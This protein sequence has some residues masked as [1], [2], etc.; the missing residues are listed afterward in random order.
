MAN[1]DKAWLG[2][3]ASKGR[4]G[5]SWLLTV[6]QAEF[7]PAGVPWSSQAIAEEP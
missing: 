4:S 6:S 5:R 2:S 7:G 1:P 3:F